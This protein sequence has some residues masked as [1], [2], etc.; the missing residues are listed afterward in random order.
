MQE[1]QVTI[2]D[3]TYDLGQHFVVIA[4]HNPLEQQGTYALLDAQ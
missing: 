1:I 2:G 3:T 4:T